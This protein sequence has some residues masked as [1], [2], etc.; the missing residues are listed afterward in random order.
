[1]HGAGALESGRLI[2]RLA[3][4]PKGPETLGKLLSL[5]DLIY[6]AVKWDHHS[7]VTG[8]QEGLPH[9]AATPV[10]GW[11]SIAGHI[12]GANLCST[13]GSPHSFTHSLIP[14][15]QGLATQCE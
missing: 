14:T 4:P 6:A 13:V 9:R 10:H 15:A 11:L 7:H 12:L 8:C 5:G 2:P 1:M 3:L